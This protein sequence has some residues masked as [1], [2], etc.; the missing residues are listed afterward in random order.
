VTAS[1]ELIDAHSLQPSDPNSQA[2]IEAVKQ[3][4][5][6]AQDPAGAPPQQH[7]VF[8]LENFSTGS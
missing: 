3:M 5:F 6:P 8:V 1:G 4:K 7:L 2:A